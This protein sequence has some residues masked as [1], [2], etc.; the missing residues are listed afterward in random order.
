MS[1]LELRQVSKAYPGVQALAGVDFDVDAG[2]VVSLLGEN[3]AGKSTLMKVVAGAVAPD[4]GE[5]RLNGSL[6]PLG[7]PTAA[8]RAGIGI[9]HQELSLVPS[10]SVGE[11]IFLGRW[12]RGALGTVSVA[13]SNSP[14]GER[15]RRVGLD[16]DPATRVERLSVADRQLVEIAKALDPHLKVLL[17]DEPTSS[18][19]ES[20]AENLFR[21]I[22]ELAADGV[23]V[24]YVSHRL[25][26]VLA[27]S[28]RVHVLRDGE[29]A[30]SVDA[31][32][33]DENSLASLMVGRVVDLDAAIARPDVPQDAEVVL[34]AEGL[35][36][37][38]RL[39]PSSLEIRRGEIVTVFGLVGA[40]RS[41]LARTLFGV[42]P[43]TTGRLTLHGK[44]RRIRSPREAISAGIGLVGDDRAKSLV[45]SLSI[46]N[47]ISLASL[48]AVRRGV[49]VNRKRERELANRYVKMLNIRTSGVNRPVSTLSGGNQQKVLLARSLCSE[50][51]I[52]LL[53][54]PVRGVDI[55][56][57]EEIFRLIRGLADEGVA[58]LYFTSEIREAKSLGSR[59]LVMAAG[60]VVAELPPDSADDRIMAAAGGVSA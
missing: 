15:L 17:L 59:I 1:I 10:M 58:I 44:T 21:V 8:R 50:A 9:V 52:L 47:N 23:A 28:Q 5:M 2:E 16:I 19:S 60:K 4:S 48:P 33:A 42:E 29:N 41:R 31:R 24:V 12:P 13:A 55:G 35:G 6:V 54:D 11:N 27:I 39:K 25:P 38:P 43:A 34:R 32:E 26:E 7:D 53:D 20:D 57:K 56:A 30:G 3:G 40:G 14:A 36:R 46:A 37:A 22:R 49:V 45:R 51:K 18:L